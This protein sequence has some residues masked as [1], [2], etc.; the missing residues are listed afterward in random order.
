[1]SDDAAKRGLERII[2]FIAAIAGIAGVAFWIWE[3]PDREEERNARQSELVARANQILKDAG[4]TGR[5]ANAEDP[6]V[7]WAVETLV[8][9]RHPVFLTAEHVTLAQLTADCAAIAVNAKSFTILG[10]HL[11]NTQI[12]WSGETFD[13]VQLEAT[14]ISFSSHAARSKADISLSNLSNANFAYGD[15]TSAQ[16]DF[17]INLRS[18]I[19][20][21]VWIAPD[22]RFAIN[23]GLESPAGP[24]KATICRLRNGKIEGSLLSTATCPVNSE[25]VR[26]ICTGG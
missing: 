24:A 9:Y 14:N 8:K 4:A 25:V 3:W 5:I 18:T 1:M 20:H 11:E 12:E 10:G 23:I 13:A 21:D 22:I 26:E 6:T 19:A 15:F 2:Y 17:D 7:G 16:A